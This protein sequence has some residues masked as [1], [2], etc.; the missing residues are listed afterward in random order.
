MFRVNL[1]QEKQKSKCFE[2]SKFCDCGRSSVTVR[3]FIY[4]FII[5][6]I[7]IEY[8]LYVNK[9]PLC[10]GYG[11]KCKQI[12]FLQRAYILAGRDK[13]KYTP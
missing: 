11:E 9:C 4:V 1:I 13:N 10:R 7:F 12:S 3:N 2:P 8:I 6:Q 5:Q